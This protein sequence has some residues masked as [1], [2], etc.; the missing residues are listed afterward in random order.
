MKGKKVLTGVLLCLTVLC[1][2]FAVACDKKE[3]P[4][5]ESISIQP[6]EVVLDLGEELNYADFT[7]TAKM[8]DG[9]QQSVKLTKAMF[10][11]DDLAKL[12]T[13][14]SYELTVNCMGKTTKLAVT[15]NA[16]E[17][18]GV[19]IEDVN[20]TY[21]GNA[22]LPE[23]KGVPAGATV[24]Y[25]IFEGTEK[26]EEHKVDSAVNAGE[27]IAEV[28][29]SAKN[30]NDY[31]KDVKITI[32][33][34]AYDMNK[35]VWENLSYTYTGSEITLAATASNLPEGIELDKFSGTLTA[36]EKGQYKATATFK[37][38]N[39]NYTVAAVEIVW[40]IMDADDIAFEPYY[41]VI[42]GK[43]F[44]AEFVASES[45]ANKGE[46]VFNGKSVDYTV[47]YAEDGKAT[48]TTAEGYLSVSVQGGV[49]SIETADNAKY[50]MITESALDKF[51]GE[52][53][54]IIEDFVI[55]FD[56]SAE[57]AVLK[58]ASAS[59]A[60]TLNV[61]AEGGSEDA[62]L[63][64]EGEDF[65]FDYDYSVN[66]IR[67]NGYKNAANYDQ[68]DQDGVYLAEKEKADEALNS[69]T[70]GKFTDYENSAV[71]E[72]KEDKSIFYNGVAVDIWCSYYDYYGYDWL[73]KVYISVNSNS[74]KQEV[75]ALGGYY[76]VAGNVFVP[77]EYAPFFGTYY[78]VAADKLDGQ[79]KIVFGEYASYYEINVY[80]DGTSVRYDF[81]KNMLK[82]ALENG[83]LSATLTPE[84][85]EAVTLVFNSEFEANIGGASYKKVD[86]LLLPPT[87]ENNVYM[88]ADGETITYDGKGSF[89]Y[90]GQVSTVFA[91]ERIAD[92]VQITLTVDGSNHVLVYDDNRYITVDGEDLFV[93]SDME[94][95]TDGR[96]ADVN[97]ISGENTVI[98]K[99]GAYQINGKTLTDM[100]YALVDDGNSNGRLVL[101]V[102]GKIEN[103]DYTV[104]HYSL[105]A[106][107]VNGETYVAEPFAG[108]YGTE[109]TPSKGARDYFE[110]TEDGKMMFRGDEIFVNDASSYTHFYLVTDGRLYYYSFDCN[111]MFLQF[112]DSIVW[113]VKY[114]PAAYFDFSGA[115]VSEDKTKVFYF[116]DTVVYYDETSTETFS[117]L[118]DE[119]GATMKLGGKIAKFYTEGKKLEYDGKNYTFVAFSLNDYVRK[120]TVYD[121][122][123]NG[124]E[125]TY[126]PSN[127]GYNAPEIKNLMMYDG[128]ITPVMG[129]GY[130]DEA[131]IIKNKDGATA[132]KLPYLAVKSDFMELVGSEMFQGKE[133]S[134]SVGTQEKPNSSELMPALIVTYDGNKAVLNKVGYS[135]NYSVEL[136]GKEYYLRANEDETTKE[137]LPL[138]VF[139]SWWA[140]YETPYESDYY[141]Y[142]GMTIGLVI[143]SNGKA[144]APETILEVTVNGEITEVSFENQS[145]NGGYM[146]FTYNGE[147]YKA[148]MATANNVKV[149]PLK[150]YE[151]EFFY[152]VENE[153][154]QVDGKDLKLAVTIDTEY[155]SSSN[156]YMT[157]FD[158]NGSSYDGKTLTFAYYVYA[159]GV[160][161]FATEENSYAYA[162]NENKFFTGV[163]SADDEYRNASPEGAYGTELD[164]IRFLAKYDSFDKETGKG[165]LNFWFDDTYRGEHVNKIEI[166]EK[167]ENGY[168]L[169][170]K[171]T[172]G[173]DVTAYLV[174]EGG[175]FMFYTVEEYLM[176]G[177]FDVNGKTLIITRS[178][179][180]GAA[181]FTAVYD[182][183]A[184]VSFAL[185]DRSVTLKASDGKTYVARWTIESGEITF[186]ADEVSESA[187]AFVGSGYAFNTNE[188]YYDW[189]LTISF[190]GIVDGKA[191]F[192][193]DWAKGWSDDGTVSGTLSDDGLFIASSAEMG[194][195]KYRIYLN[196]TSDVDVLYVM[197]K[198]EA[199]V[200]KLIGNFTL[201][202][203]KLEIGVGATAAYDYD[204]EFDGIESK[205][206]IVKLNGKNCTDISSFSVSA[207]SVT[208]TCDGV[209]YSFDGTDLSVVQQ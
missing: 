128:E 41:G 52:Y 70:V 47:D 169:T 176:N 12:N 175:V 20:A 106:L 180:N 153:T 197:V 85:G 143:K 56:K 77:E 122:S 111:N 86:E 93:Y 71:L 142:N 84:T 147:K 95:D 174:K 126:D 66:N 50:V 188:S 43:M 48:V 51:E 108:I 154:R 103:A 38:E 165:V 134:I 33:K 208:F 24:S 109:F 3:Q 34:A 110:F 23:V 69:F 11:S 168:K 96:I 94:N 5:A 115:Y 40:K 195:S 31:K 73:F 171:N 123:A 151:F 83:V 200:A 112:H 2:S 201:G 18:S 205:E 101:E 152:N 131:Y 173:K 98:Y 198:P 88:N 135:S 113:N 87:Y 167:V 177:S 60:L 178:V 79:N 65:T 14:G 172:E 156:G 64:V 148:V 144:E 125:I 7:I 78:L 127:N 30:Y 45:E 145:A 182:G 209:N 139:E 59:F 102:K 81:S 90:K 63:A 27:Y 9:S 6:A 163:L 22:V 155:Y 141:F 54:I 80:T 16:L 62:Y 91:I 184:S 61:P 68:V 29:V 28:T 114:Y 189:E 186:T 42:D 193:I 119:T 206:F 32:G 104:L 159:D 82:F 150:E 118:S 137:D 196:Q 26:T 192:S 160:L 74:L 105:A 164:D 67:L 46:F 4:V 13:A 185:A 49:L 15:V 191:T 53:S 158:L 107:K 187:L 89:T 179:K 194:G 75:E 57:T 36:K 132:A 116:G 1:L 121:G 129:Y 44:K 140:D 183:G 133:L 204:D 120:Y 117:V 58:T 136:G 166:F 138:L 124:T 130:G 39:R 97:Y 162:I 8:S 35:V 55:T 21:S 99:N 170:G 207:A 181:V 76:K 25:V 199:E 203:N 72:I 149:L 146:I 100:S 17:M 92:G 157:S 161:M 37:G 19:T 202:E 10:S 190:A